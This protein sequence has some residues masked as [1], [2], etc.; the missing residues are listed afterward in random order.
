VIRGAVESV[1]GANFMEGNSVE[2]LKNGV[3]IFP[4]MKEAIGGAKR[5]IDLVTFVYWTGQIARDVA[6]LL[7]E[8][9][10]AGVRV[11][12]VLDAFGSSAMDDGLI[13]QMRGAGVAVER[14]RPFVRWKFWEADHRTHRKILIVDDSVAFTGG[15]GIAEEWEGDA[16]KPDEWRDTHFRIE[17]PAVLGLKATFLADW[18]DTGHPIDPTDAEEKR[19]DHR[20][21]ALM[22]VVDASAQIGFNAAQR[23]LEALVASAQQRIVVQTPY[24]NPDDAVREKLAEAVRRGVD[25]DIL[26]PGPHIDKRVSAVV[27]EE[28]YERLIES[29]IRVWLYQPTMM[30]AKAMLV[31]GLLSFVGSVNF[32]QRSVQKD[33]EA[34]VVILDREITRTLEDHFRADVMHSELARPS[35]DGRPLRRRLAAKVLRPINKEF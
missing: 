8:R 35:V 22:T 34:A 31:D 3:E 25:V 20:G 19:L 23:V 18:R 10:K 28:E 24:F 9:S 21:D 11:R 2:V 32:N 29:G 5:S 14:F 26:L 33:E 30:H 17:G 6:D 27:A 15:V 4:A 1:I 7:S 12:V 16:T 13:E